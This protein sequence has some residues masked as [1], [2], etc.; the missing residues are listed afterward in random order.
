MSEKIV[1]Y[2]L[3]KNKVTNFENEIKY[4]D[5][6]INYLESLLKKQKSNIN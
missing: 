1:D 2:D 5:S 6:I 3:I 4:K